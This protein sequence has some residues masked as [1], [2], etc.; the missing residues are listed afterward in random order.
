MASILKVDAMQG[1]TSAGDITITDGATTFKMQSA[2]NKMWI[3]YDG[4]NNSIFASLNV[5]SVTDNGTGNYTY[6]FS[7]NFNAAE[8]YSS[9]MSVVLQSS[10]SMGSY[11]THGDATTTGIKVHP[12]RNTSGSNI[13]VNNTTMNCCGDLA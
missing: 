1:V 2:L 7:N 6:N 3:A 9:A 10:P 12:A 4:I 8:E 5:G 11:T 13:D